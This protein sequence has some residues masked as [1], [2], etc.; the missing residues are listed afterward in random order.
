VPPQFA[1]LKPQTVY[2]HAPESPNEWPEVNIKA[3]NTI[4]VFQVGF[5]GTK[6]AF[7]V[8]NTNAFYGIEVACGTDAD[9]YY[10]RPPQFSLR[11]RWFSNDGHSHYRKIAKGIFEIY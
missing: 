8:D 3:F 1:A 11:N 6:R 10:P 2:Y 5:F 4:P 7:G 9:I